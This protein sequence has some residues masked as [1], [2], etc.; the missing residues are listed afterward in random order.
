MSSSDRRAFIALAAAIAVLPGCFR[1]MLAEGGGA[2]ELRG[3]IALPSPSDR[4]QFH[5]HDS[6]EE[7]LGKPDAPDYRLEVAVAL[8]ES[9]LLVAQDNT[10]T[11]LRMQAVAD[12]RLYRSGYAEPVLADRIVSESGYDSTASL[13]SSRT[14][15]KDIER[16]LARDLGERIA[17]RIQ[18][19]A[20]RI[21]ATAQG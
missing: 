21:G 6:L 15:K 17:R 20:G 8:S 19:Q 7:R 11:R 18:A 14:T 2:A 13:Y 3:R 1:P 10:I 16:R 5:M 12:F 9:G 4:F